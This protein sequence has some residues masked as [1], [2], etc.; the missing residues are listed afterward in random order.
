L[1]LTSQKY[2]IKKQNTIKKG[3]IRFALK[4]YYVTF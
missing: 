2:N 3:E 4:V 1:T